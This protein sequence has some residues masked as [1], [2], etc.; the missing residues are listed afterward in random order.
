MA[1]ASSL[2]VPVKFDISL[3]AKYF[4]SR[5]NV[6]FRRSRDPHSLEPFQQ[7]VEKLLFNRCRWRC[8]WCARIHCGRFSQFIRFVRR[9]WRKAVVWNWL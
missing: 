7:S 2:V 3:G 5:F 8:S 4:L 1:L 6:W 9:R